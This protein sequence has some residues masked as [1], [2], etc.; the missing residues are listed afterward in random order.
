MSERT[1][2]RRSVLKACGTACLG[3]TAAATSAEE[4]TGKPTNESAD[5]TASAGRDG[6]S[7]TYSG[8]VT[9][10][11]EHVLVVVDGGPQPARQ[12]VF[13]RTELPAVE[14]GDSVSLWLWRGRVVYV[15]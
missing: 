13:D 2:T 5:S 8:T 11:G 6:R 9:Y 4:A 7:G 1:A 3:T 14:E 12:F 10:V 15:W